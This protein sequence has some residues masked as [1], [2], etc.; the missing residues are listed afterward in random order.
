[1][2]TEQERRV[3][4]IADYRK[5]LDFL[6]KHPEVP[7]GQSELNSFCMPTGDDAVQL[8]K[9][10]RIAEALGVEVV[11]KPGSAAEV[12]R[13]FGNVTYTAFYNLSADMDRHYEE[14]RWL[15]EQR[16]LKAAERE[17]GG[18]DA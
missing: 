1:M 8:A 17:A 9:L 15:K 18:S 6:A 14:Q 4:I 10:Q 16:A 3:E 11:R 7:L 2:S 12:T 13:S 5:L